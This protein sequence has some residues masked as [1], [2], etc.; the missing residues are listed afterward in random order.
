MKGIILKLICG[1]VLVSLIQACSTNKDSNVDIAKIEKNVIVTVESVDNG[2][3]SPYRI[4][5]ILNKNKQT[6]DV[7]GLIN[8][9][10][11]Q[12]VKIGSNTIKKVT[13]IARNQTVV[14]S[15]KNQEAY[16]NVARY[17][18]KVTAK[19]SAK[20]SLYKELDIDS[21]EDGENIVARIRNH[22][23]Q[24]ITNL[25]I[26]CVYYKDNKAVSFV[27]TKVKIIAADS[28]KKINIS[29]PVNSDMSAIGYDTYE[30]Y[31]ENTY[32]D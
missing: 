4:V 20:T 5:K 17:D 14:Y 10:D 12:D 29:R 24:K 15:M 11:D 30:I 9:Y 1:L 3:E 27:M 16:K 7:S 31:L 23:D 28:T 13:A 6:V 21:E 18:I 22:S 25:K 8:Y 19:V 26:A 2:V 32:Q